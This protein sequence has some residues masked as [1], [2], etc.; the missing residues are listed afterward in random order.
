MNK[1]DRQPRP[2]SATSAVL[3][4]STSRRHQPQLSSSSK[5]LQTAGSAS[6][7]PILQHNPGVLER[8]LGGFLGVGGSGGAVFYVCGA[9]AELVLGQMGAV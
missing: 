9:L 3:N 8:F 5:R 2:V 1:R 4:V 7:K 6:K